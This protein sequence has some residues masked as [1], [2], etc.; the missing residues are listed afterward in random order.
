MDVDDSGSEDS[1]MEPEPVAKRKQVSS[2]QYM[3]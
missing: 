1:D 3:I 2:S